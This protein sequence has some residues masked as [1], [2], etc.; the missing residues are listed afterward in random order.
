[1]WRSVQF[2]LPPRIPHLPIRNFLTPY[3]IKFL[4]PFPAV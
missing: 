3:I 1:L 2:R 4:T